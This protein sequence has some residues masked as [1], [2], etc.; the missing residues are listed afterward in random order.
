M[1]KLTKL[2]ENFNFE[3]KDEKLTRDV[4]VTNL[5]GLE[6]QKELLKETAESREAYKLAINM[7]LEMRNQHQIQAYKKELVAESESAIKYS[8]NSRAANW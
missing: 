3:N 6:I 8:N 5:L 4:F 1:E 7:E 2:T